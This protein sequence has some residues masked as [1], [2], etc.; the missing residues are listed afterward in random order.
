MKQIINGADFRRM[1]I[2][3]AAAIEMNKQALNEL[4]VFPVPDGDTGTNMSMTI[5]AA[6]ADLRKAED[7]DLGQAA[8]IAASAMLRGARGNSGVILS[9][10]LRGISKQL[11]GTETSDGVLWAQA[12]Q[13]GV[14]AAYKAVMKPAEGTILTVARLAAAGKITISNL[15]RKLPLPRQRPLWPIPS[16]R[17]RC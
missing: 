10:L 1:M 6:A 16:T 17:T 11:K 12:L 7:P 8:K 3:A 4:N 5:N 13:E 2:S 15:S 9:L 14:D